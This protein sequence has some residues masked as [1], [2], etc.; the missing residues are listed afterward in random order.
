MLS[1]DLIKKG[2]NRLIECEGVESV[3]YG[4]TKWS[5]SH[6]IE[7]TPS[8][9]YKSESFLE[10]EFAIIDEF[11]TSFPN[12]EIIFITNDD[13]ISLTSVVYTATPESISQHITPTL[14][15]GFKKHNFEVIAGCSDY[16]NEGNYPLAA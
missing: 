4:F 16:N 8:E 10:I 13:I 2:A 3:R 9:V 12:E 11:E 14:K 6:I 1:S 5:D 15:I 7:V